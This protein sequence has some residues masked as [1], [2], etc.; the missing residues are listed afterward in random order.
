MDI[1]TNPI[2]EPQKTTSGK[3]KRQLSNLEIAAFCEQ[4]AMIVSAGLPTYEGIVIL[5]EDAPDAETKAILSSI[6]KP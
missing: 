4:I 3:K 6:Y 2:E 5:M 1:Q